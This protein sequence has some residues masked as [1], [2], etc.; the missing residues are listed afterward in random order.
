MVYVAA[1]GLLVVAVVVGVLVESL[2]AAAPDVVV[3]VVLEVV[4]R[5]VTRPLR[6]DCDEYLVSALQ[7]IGLKCEVRIA[8]SHIGR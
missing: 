1:G 6:V 8:N 5:R 4:C 7:R 2:L 3:V